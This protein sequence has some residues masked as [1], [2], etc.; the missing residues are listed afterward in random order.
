MNHSSTSNLNANMTTQAPQ[1]SLVGYPTQ[2]SVM[3]ALASGRSYTWWTK[4][5]PYPEG[6]PVRRLQSSPGVPVSHVSLCV[7]FLREATFFVVDSV[8]PGG[9]QCLA[10]DSSSASYLPRHPSTINRM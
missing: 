2:V 5:S 9:P 1:V 3:A 8:S 4:Y 6:G 7:S 10:L